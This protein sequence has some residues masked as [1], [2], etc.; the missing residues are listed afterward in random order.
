LRG[1]QGWHAQGASAHAA[2]MA[3]EKSCYDGG[4]CEDEANAY[5]W[6][7]IFSENRCPLLGIMLYTV[8][9]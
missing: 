9:A 6:S 3:R 7:M 5:W 1:W 2:A 4:T 8:S